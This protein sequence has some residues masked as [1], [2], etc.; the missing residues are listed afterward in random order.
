MYCSQFMTTY[1]IGTVYATAQGIVK[2]EI[3]DMSGQ[4]MIKPAAQSEL[5]PECTSSEITT[6]AAHLLQRYF[7]GEKVDFSVIPVVLDDVPPFWS[8]VLIWI[9]SLQ[10]GHICS[11]GQVALA[12]GSP[13]ASRAV[14]GA[15]ASNPIPVI[16]PCHRVVAADGRLTGFSAPGGES[17]KRA[18]LLMEG[19]EFK[20]VQVVI[21]QLVMHKV[22]C[23]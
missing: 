10:Y 3:P 23:R 2:A 4:E 12:C 15:L 21:P 7:L 13:R 20:G 1:G 16:V 17:T 5:K 14:G 18:L 22:P 9:R 19:V 6:A 8:K 11:Y